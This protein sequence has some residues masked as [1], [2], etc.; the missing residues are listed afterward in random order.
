[1]FQEPTTTS[2]ESATAK[3]TGIQLMV[4]LMYFANFL[5]YTL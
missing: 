5:A 3:T 2:F 4:S 1:L